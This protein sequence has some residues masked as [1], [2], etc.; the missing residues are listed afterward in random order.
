[1][2][3]ICEQDIHYK[4][5]IQTMSNSDRFLSYQRQISLAKQ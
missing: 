1:M 2:Y 5:W 4:K 3:V